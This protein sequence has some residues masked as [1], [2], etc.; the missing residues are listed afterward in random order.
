MMNELQPSPQQYA[1]EN[2]SMNTQSYFDQLDSSDSYQ[3]TSQSPPIGL[4]PKQLYPSTDQAP[5]VIRTATKIV[6]KVVT[7]VGSQP[8]QDERSVDYFLDKAQSLPETSNLSS[9]ITR[10]LG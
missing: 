4:S 1:A 2:V 3:N 6:R 5:A 9:R 10:N 7:T 8:M